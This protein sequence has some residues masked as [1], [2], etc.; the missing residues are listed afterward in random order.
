MKYDSMKHKYAVVQYGC[1]LFGVG[2]SR[3]RAIADAAQWIEPNG[4]IQGHGT[5]QDVEKLLNHGN[6]ERMGGEFYVITDSE[7]IRQYVDC[8]AGAA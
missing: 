7:E 1:A 2:E 3:E 4:K 8:R 6:G 5:V